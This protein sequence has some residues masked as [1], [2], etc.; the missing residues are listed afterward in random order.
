MRFSV[1]S[2][3]KIWYLLC[4]VLLR[5]KRHKFPERF[6]DSC[7]GSTVCE[8]LA[9]GCKKKNSTRKLTDYSVLCRV[10]CDN[11][12][13]ENGFHL[14]DVICT[15]FTTSWLTESGWLKRHLAPA[16]TGKDLRM[17]LW[18][19]VNNETVP[20]NTANALTAFRSSIHSKSRTWWPRQECKPTDPQLW[21]SNPR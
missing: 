14:Q 12:V 18:P 15:W 19:Q 11:I 21:R 7:F 20:L 16:V 1:H 3:A 9:Q 5:R 4:S 8:L 17:R 6:L 10:K 2:S 13:E